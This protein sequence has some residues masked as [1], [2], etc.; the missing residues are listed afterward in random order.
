MALSGRKQKVG[1]RT[2]LGFQV[3]GDFHLIREVEAVL[4]C[5]LT[6]HDALDDERP[7]SAEGDGRHLELLALDLQQRDV[8]VGGEE[9]MRGQYAVITFLLPRR[10]RGMSRRTIQAARCS[11]VCLRQVRERFGSRVRDPKQPDRPSRRTSLLGQTPAARVSRLVD[12][13]RASLL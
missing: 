10:P 6:Q 1:R 13:S 11:T 12:V 5:D 7:H 2:H 8:S 9:I 3:L 4:L